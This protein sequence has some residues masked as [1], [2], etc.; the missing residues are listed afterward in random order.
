MTEILAPDAAARI[1]LIIAKIA[2]YSADGRL[3]PFELR[4][5]GED[6]ILLIDPDAAYRAAERWVL[7]LLYR[8]AADHRRAAGRK[9]ARVARAEATGRAL[10]GL[11]K[12]EAVRADAIAHLAAAAALE[13]A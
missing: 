7:D 6:L 10:I 1:P 4:D 2:A 12:I 3:D 9:L 13:G 5:I 8:D 11:R